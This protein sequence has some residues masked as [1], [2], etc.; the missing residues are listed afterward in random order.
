M[1]SALTSLRTGLLLLLVLVGGRAA[2]ADAPYSDARFWRVERD[3]AEPSFILGTMHVTDPEVTALPPAVSRAFEG[4]RALAVELTMDTATQVILQSAALTADIDWIDRRLDERQ[5]G[6]LA[7]AAGRYQIPVAN[8]RV[9]EPWAVTAMFSFPPSELQR[10]MR[11]LQ[12]LDMQLMDKAEASGKRLIALERVE[13]QLEAFAGYSD[14]EQIAMLT[15][16]LESVGSVEGDFA[17]MKGAYLA[18]DLADLSALADEGFAK[19]DPAL[20]GRVQ[21]RLIADRNRHMADRLEPLLNQGRLFVAV[22]A[23]HLPGEGGVL[24]LLAQRGYRI[25]AVE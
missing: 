18:G 23:L 20:S 2:L 14:Q 25:T 13:E 10:Q 16:T 11:G 5:R 3:G 8:L 6:L 15:Q 22:G 9:L 1:R 7:D 4:S 24:N 17:R 21:Q 12:P 19:L